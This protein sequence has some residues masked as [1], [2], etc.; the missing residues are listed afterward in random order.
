MDK[1]KD[2]SIYIINYYTNLLLH[3]RLQA[4][5]WKDFR[6]NEISPEDFAGWRQSDFYPQFPLPS[7]DVSLLLHNND[8]EV[9]EYAL[10]LTAE[11]P[12]T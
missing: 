6:K 1:E 8:Q 12:N 3:T 4:T 5:T 7:E 11:Y 2:L 10:D 9:V